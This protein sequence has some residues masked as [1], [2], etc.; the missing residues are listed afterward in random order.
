MRFILL[1]LIVALS[2]GYMYAVAATGVC[3][4]YSRSLDGHPTAGGDKS[5]VVTVNALTAARRKARN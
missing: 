4:F 1:P 3:S 5:V 2:A